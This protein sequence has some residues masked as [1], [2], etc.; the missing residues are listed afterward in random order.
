MTL[1]FDLTE[2]FRVKSIFYHLSTKLTLKAGYD[3]SSIDPM[4]SVGS[5]R[6][7]KLSRHV[8]NS[9]SHWLFAVRGTNTA[10]RHMASLI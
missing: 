4:A 8:L 10:K 5:Q 7:I 1:P 2:A 3:E 9:V 6:S